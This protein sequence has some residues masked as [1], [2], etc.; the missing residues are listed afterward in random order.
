M[1]LP[2]SCARKPIPLFSLPFVSHPDGALWLWLAWLGLGG[3]LTLPIYKLFP[4]DLPPLP[5][6]G[7]ASVIGGLLVDR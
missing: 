6:L 2:L 7:S 3:L 5:M 4:A 1:P